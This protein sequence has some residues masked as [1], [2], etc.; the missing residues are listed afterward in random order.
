MNPQTFIQKNST[1]SRYLRHRR[2]FSPASRTAPIRRSNLRQSAPSVVSPPPSSLRYQ[3]SSLLPPA[4]F[5]RCSLPAEAGSFADKE[6][7]PPKFRRIQ[8][9]LP[10]SV[11]Q[12]PGDHVLRVAVY[13]PGR[14][15]SCLPAIQ[16]NSTCPGS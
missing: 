10:P 5:A 15:A 12:R 8:L 4:S 6:S 2:L 11:A 3:V 16:P 14:V 7:W 9:P 1:F 13:P